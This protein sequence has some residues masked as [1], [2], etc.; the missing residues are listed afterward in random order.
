MSREE[1]KISRPDIRLTQQADAR[2]F[3]VE[4]RSVPDLKGKAAVLAGRPPGPPSPCGRPP[5]TCAKPCRPCRRSGEEP[6]TPTAIK[7]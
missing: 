4:V 1:L 3:N 2:E 5:C 7:K 6:A